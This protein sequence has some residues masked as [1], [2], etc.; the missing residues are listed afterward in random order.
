MDARVTRLIAL[1]ESCTGFAAQQVRGAGLNRFKG[2]LPA[3]ARL[4]R[5]ASLLKA[6]GNHADEEG[7]Q[8]G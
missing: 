8:H 6:L 5:L 2:L 4:Q 7:D 3:F 1:A